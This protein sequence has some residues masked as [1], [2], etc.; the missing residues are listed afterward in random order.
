MDKIT[1]NH[2]P[3]ITMHGLFG[4]VWLSIELFLG[5]ATLANDESMKE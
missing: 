1:L 2:R 3:S 4:Y 5:T